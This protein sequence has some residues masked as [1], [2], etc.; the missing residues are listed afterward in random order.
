MDNLKNFLEDHKDEMDF[1]SPS[2]EVW[3][4][5]NKPVKKAPVISIKKMLYAAAAACVLLVAGLLYVMQEQKETMSGEKVIASEGKIKLPDE[6]TITQ[7]LL[8][9]TEQPSLVSTTI[10]KP[11]KK[12]NKIKQ[13]AGNTIDNEVQMAVKSIDENFDKILNAQI[14]NI[15]QT[16]IYA[17]NKDM[18][19]GFKNQYRQLETEEKQL[20]TD[21]ANFGMEEQLLQQLIFINQQKLNL[22]KSLQVEISKVNNNIPSQQKHKQHFLKM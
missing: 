10:E 19:G 5:L 15:S 6:V 2:P 9:T 3:Q 13:N 17:E 21:I 4:K 1:E 12:T 11:L 16:P 14:K 7:P 22:L 20:K 18:F 8:E